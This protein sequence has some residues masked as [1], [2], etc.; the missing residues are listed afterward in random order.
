MVAEETPPQNQQILHV[1]VRPW[2]YPANVLLCGRFR[3]LGT[4]TLVDVELVELRDKLRRALGGK[5]C[6]RRVEHAL[7]QCFNAYGD[8]HGAPCACGP[9]ARAAASGA[10]TAARAG[11]LDHFNLL[12]LIHGVLYSKCLWDERL[13]GWKVERSELDFA[14]IPFYRII[15]I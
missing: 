13:L 2:T 5:L 4:Q 14:V 10:R 11:P 15:V 8:R 3:R 6:P 1:A 12:D 9:A 7:H